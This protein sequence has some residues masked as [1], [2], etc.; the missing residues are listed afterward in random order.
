VRRYKGKDLDPQIVAKDLTVQALVTGHV[1]QQGDSL[2]VSTELV[3]TDNN[4][5][6]SFFDNWEWANAER[7]YQRALELDAKFANAHHW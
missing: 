7:E 4:R 3:D 6:L 5:I 1:S 2:V